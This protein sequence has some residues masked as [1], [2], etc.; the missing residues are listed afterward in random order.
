MQF[1]LHMQHTSKGPFGVLLM[2][3]GAVRIG[4]WRTYR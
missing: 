3:I 2:F 4:R 1:D